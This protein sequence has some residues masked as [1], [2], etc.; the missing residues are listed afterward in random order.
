MEHD[1]E[2]DGQ[3]PEE[4]DRIRDVCA[5]DRDDTDVREVGREATDRVGRQDS[6]RDAAVQRQRHLDQRLGG[7]APQRRAGRWP[8]SGTEGNDRNC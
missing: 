4:R 6:L 8:P 2:H 7:R 1:R 3:H 5:G